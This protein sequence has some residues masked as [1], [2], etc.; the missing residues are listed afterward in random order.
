MCFFLLAQRSF[1]PYV[2][3]PLRV[4]KKKFYIIFISV[5][6]SNYGA[7]PSVNSEDLVKAKKSLFQLTASKQKTINCKDGEWGR[8]I[9]RLGGE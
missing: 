6:C 1:R 9:R 5:L 4:G 3:F 7:R 8:A 2:C